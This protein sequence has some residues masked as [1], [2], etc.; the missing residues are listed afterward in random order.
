MIYLFEDKEGRMA[1][2]LKGEVDNNLLRRAIM[3]SKKDEID[4]YIDANFKDADAVLFHVSYSLP[5]QGV[6]NDIVREAF[7]SKG[8]PFIYFSGGSH[9]SLSKT[10]E[11]VPTA[12]IRSEDMYTHLPDFIEDF[13]ATGKVNIPLLVFGRSY[14]MNSLL[15]VM[16]WVNDQLWGLKRDEP[17][18]P[19]VART[20]VSG[21]R[22]YIQ[23]DELK[24]DKNT[25]LEFISSHLTSGD[26]TPDS[27]IGQLQKIIDKH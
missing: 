26:L 9:N 8:I 16:V 18:S 27:I 12:D 25:L 22:S 1:L 17:I 4:Q 23:E 14:L 21:I 11:G 15:K 20:L 3:D 5:Q 19:A 7:L 10:P 13:K 24:E 2:Y 6:T